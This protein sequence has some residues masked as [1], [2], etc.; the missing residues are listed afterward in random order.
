MRGKKK[1][2]ASVLADT[3]MLRVAR[4]V[5]GRR[6]ERL[7]VLAYHRVL[8]AIEP[9]FSGDE[10]LVS[11]LLDDFRWQMRFVAAECTPV[12]IE[13]VIA[14][15]RGEDVLP[16]RAVLVTF[17]DGCV[18]AIRYALPVLK[19]AAIP[20]VFFVSSGYIGGRELYWF[21]DVV[22]RFMRCERSGFR[23]ETLG[24]EVRLSMDRAVRKQAADRVV[25]ALKLAADS[26]RLAALAE[27]R[28]NCGL[29]LPEHV[30]DA[31]RPM[32]WAE[33]RSLVQQGMS[34]G[35][36]SVTHPVLAGL[37]DSELARELEESRRAI[38]RE[39]ACPC[40]AIAYPLGGDQGYSMSGAIALDDRVRRHAAAAGYL[41]GFTYIPG[42]ARLG[43]DD[44]LR[45][46][47]VAVERYLTRDEFA[48]RLSIPGVFL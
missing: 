8:P 27:V 11:A 46:N 23:L 5:N 9:T 3:G 16:P 24:I 44:P 20:A 30:I 33:V 21:D 19:E 42:I 26:T 34:V 28:E 25:R 38:E 45:L 40:P 17:D 36:H 15:V 2:L 37:T 29:T 14:A 1:L 6:R 43:A 35:S 47:R 32:T 41:A 18:D 10:E 12:M 31:N 7:A 39:L 4:A 22:H 48:A 13:R